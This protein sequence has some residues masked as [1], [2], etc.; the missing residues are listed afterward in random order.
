MNRI[1]KL[2]ITKISFKG[3][4]IKVIIAFLKS[5]FRKWL[6]EEVWLEDYVKRGM[7]IGSGCSIQPGVIFD[8]SHC[9]LISIGNNVTLAPYVYIL[10][11]DASTKRKLGYTKVASVIIEEDV[12]IGACSMIMPGVTVGKNCIVGACSVVTK[13]VPPNSVIAGNPAKI[14]SSFDS[15]MLK[16][17]ELMKATHLFDE[18]YTFKNGDIPQKYKEE[19]F[20][21]L[22]D[23][24]GFIK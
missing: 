21:K 10:A 15:S 17:L 4:N 1:V 18:S 11:H 16:N 22:K 14:I 12:F 24:L 3:V 9:N 20:N 5:R 7:K 8:Y 6:F 19:M 2:V 13:S 23:K